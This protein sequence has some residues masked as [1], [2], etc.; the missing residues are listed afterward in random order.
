MSTTSGNN[1]KNTLLGVGAALIVALLG[2][3]IFL[4]V[5]RGQDKQQIGSLTENLDETTKLKE[6]LNKQYMSALTELEDMRGTNEELNALIDQQ[7]QELTAQKSKIDGMLRTKGDLTRA[8]AEIAK[9]QEQ[10]QQYLAEINQL[11]GENETLKGD[12]SRLSAEKT[13]LE[14][15][16]SAA[17]TSNQELS[18]AKGQLETQKA[19]LEATKTALSKKVNQASVIKL[20]DVEVTPLAI[21]ESGKPTK[22]SAAKS[23]DQLD[24]CFKIIPNEVAEVGK[25]MFHVR[26]VSPTGETLA[27]ES[28]GSGSFTNDNGES[29]PFTKAKE[30]SY[31]R[32]TANLCV[33]WNPGQPFAAGTYKVE[34]YNKGYLAGTG[35][36]KLK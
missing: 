6:E 5:N 15:N 18:A 21:K 27:V 23:V 8:R 19:E 36:V 30:T 32:G 17:N 20:D 11:K 14:G 9:M 35:S 34:V 28:M 26:I 22:K 25:E 12:N 4:W 16:L 31:N 29:I 1:S 3:N 13:T 24:V 7:K 2:L 33:S 10:A